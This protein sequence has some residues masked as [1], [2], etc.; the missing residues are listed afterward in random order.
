MNVSSVRVPGGISDRVRVEIE[1]E[2]LELITNVNHPLMDCHGAKN[3]THSVDERV[4]RA[5]CPSRLINCGL[6]G[7][8]VNI[9]VPAQLKTQ[10]VSQLLL[11]TAP[12][13]GSEQRL[14]LRA[15]T[16][17]TSVANLNS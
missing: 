12:R 15:D 13:L 1:V 16:K 17:E 2:D 8:L 7:V 5:I 6:S 4:A 9:S 11:P 3:F 14:T 10:N